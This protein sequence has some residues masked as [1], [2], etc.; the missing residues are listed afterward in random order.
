MLKK[1]L[2]TGYLLATTA[3]PVQ[4]LPIWAELIARSQCEY[5][6]MGVDWETAIEQSLRDNAHWADEFMHNRPLAAK[7]IVHAAYQICPAV[8][9][10]AYQDY[11]R[12]QETKPANATYY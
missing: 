12:Q 8:Y 4:A 6:A 3:L 1:I 2:F 9:G 11:E 7:A 10:Q 5:M